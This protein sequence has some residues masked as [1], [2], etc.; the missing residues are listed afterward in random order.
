MAKLFKDIFD[1]DFFD[2]LIKA[3]GEIVITFDSTTFLKEI[4]DDDWSSLEFKQRMRHISTV[5][6]NYLSS[7]FREASEQ[8]LSMVSYFQNNGISEETIEFMFIPDYFEQY[9]LDYFDISVTAF[10]K[11]TSFTSC[12]FAVRPFIIKYHDKM[13]EKLLAWTNHSKFA[14]RRLASEGCRPRLPWAMA[15]P[16]LKKN[17]S[18]ILPILENLKSDTEELVRRSVAN[19]LN[20]ISKDNP[21]VVI[22]L[23]KDWQGISKESDWVVKH[24]CRTLLK[25]G[26]KEVMQL[27]GFGSI[28]K[29]ELSKF[30]IEV[31][32]VRIGE[33]L[34]FRFNICNQSDI[35]EN[36]RLEY[37]IYYKKANGALSRK[38]FKIS[39]KEYSSKSEMQI[40][41]K[42]PFKIITTRTFYPGKHKVS[43]ILNGNEIEEREFELV[44]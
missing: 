2:C 44:D 28:D 29:I 34:E 3:I 11:I 15:L 37:G 14:V 8:L 22:K 23:A 12:E 41:R 35:Q 26:N 40:I 27:F 21:E 4:Y 6:K 25:Q 17:P 5:L 9:G 19:N 43:L 7:D 32:T 1:T 20:D 38:V 16:A 31:H 36:I 10:E 13:I 30:K 33:S 18:S 24:A 42:H 39:E